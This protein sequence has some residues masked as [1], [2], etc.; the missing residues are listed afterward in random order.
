MYRTFFYLS[1]L[2]PI[3]G[4][5]YNKVKY[6]RIHVEIGLFVEIITKGTFNYGKNLVIGSQSRIYINRIENRLDIGNNVNISRNCFIQPYKYIKI[7]NNVNIQHGVEI[8]GE[9]SI[10]NDVI[11]AEGVFMTSA[12]HIF[13]R[14][15]GLTIREQ[16]KKYSNVKPIVIEDDIWLGRNVTVLQGVTIKKGCVIGAGSVV[17]KDTEEYSVYVGVPAK[18][19]KDRYS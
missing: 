8:H 18:K 13:D 16:D 15:K 1:K 19:I 3:V 9:V 17:T 5:I 2:F 11:I 14:E 7:G 6:P 10:G 4:F 12:N